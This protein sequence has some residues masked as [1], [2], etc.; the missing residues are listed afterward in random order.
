MPRWPGG[1]QGRMDVASQWPHMAGPRLVVYHED[2]EILPY[3]SVSLAEAL[4]N[5]AC[6]SGSARSSNDQGWVH[7]LVALPAR[8]AATIAGCFSA[9]NSSTYQPCRKQFGVPFQD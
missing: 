9:G 3:A 7:S 4:E 1:V 2:D 6:S 8:G 5:A